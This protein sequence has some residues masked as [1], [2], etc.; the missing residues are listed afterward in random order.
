MSPQEAIVDVLLAAGVA[1]ELAC[2]LGLLMMRDA[3][4]RLHY[5]MAASSVGPVLIVAAVVVRES[6]TQPGVNAI[7]VGAFLFLLSPVLAHATARAIRKRET[8]EI[9]ARA[10]EKVEA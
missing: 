9:R 7:A 10:A 1:C 6:F 8:G 5:S 2:C 3:I 4:G